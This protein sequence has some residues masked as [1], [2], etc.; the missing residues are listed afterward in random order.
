MTKQQALVQ[1]HEPCRLTFWS[2][3]VWKQERHPC[4]SQSRKTT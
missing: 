3:C 2:H 4:I 1:P